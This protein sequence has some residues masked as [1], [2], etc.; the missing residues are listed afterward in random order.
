M[1]SAYIFLNLPSL[2]DEVLLL[3]LIEIRSRL[4]CTWIT[5]VVLND[6]FVLRLFGPDCNSLQ[7]KSI[8]VH[9]QAVHHRICFPDLILPILSTSSNA[10]FNRKSYI[11][12]EVLKDKGILIS[13]KHS[14]LHQTEQ[15]QFRSNVTL[16]RFNH[17]L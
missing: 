3:T 7:Y 17:L 16:C 15:V 1:D 10:F 14:V 5:Q 12:F 2:N 11:R 4:R 9:L 13:L 6:L 8:A